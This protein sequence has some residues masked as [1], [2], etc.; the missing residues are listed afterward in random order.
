MW[1][2][3]WVRFN[4][5]GRV[6]L[7]NL[8][9]YGLA[10]GSLSVVSCSGQRD[11]SLGR[12]HADDSRDSTVQNTTPASDAGAESSQAASDPSAEGG[13]VT[14][15]ADSEN[16]TTTSDSSLAPIDGCPELSLS[17]ES[18][19]AVGEGIITIDA[20][21]DG[22]PFPVRVEVLQSL[23]PEMAERW[24]PNTDAQDVPPEEWD[25]SEIPAGACVIRFLEMAGRCYGTTGAS[26]VTRLA[27]LMDGE[28]RTMGWI[29]Y[30]EYIRERPEHCSYA[31]GCPSSKFYAPIQWFYL[32]EKWARSLL[33]VVFANVHRAG[34]H[35]AARFVCVI[36][37]PL[38]RVN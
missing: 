26:L 29:R 28:P 7:V 9:I 36:V 34:R 2:W 11:T 1:H 3:S 21:L 17:F 6:L 8:G 32:R 13:I 19:P 22:E 38:R 14:S 25:R 10:S 27:P 31:P 30:D 18:L 23:D 37:R 12:T 5:L 15:G 24:N 16:S 33:R 4:R 35:N 20:R